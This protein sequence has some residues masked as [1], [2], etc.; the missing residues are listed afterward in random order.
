MKTIS[1][2]DSVGLG[3]SSLCIIHCLFLPIL[4]TSLPILGVLSE[5]EWLHKALVICAVAIALSFITTTS[6]R[7]LQILGGLGAILLTAAAFMPQ[8][9]DVEAVMT[10]FGGLALGLAHT[11][12]LLR[13]RHSH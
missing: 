2:V 4:G 3:V 8:F 12:R 10:L 6:R 7:R 13:P 5:Y 11:L 9:H 1:Y